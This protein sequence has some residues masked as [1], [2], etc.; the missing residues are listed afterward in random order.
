VSLEGAVFTA[1][2]HGNGS[3]GGTAGA[4][5]NVDNKGGGVITGLL[6]TF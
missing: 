3:T 5:V 6:L 1:K 4:L 2:F